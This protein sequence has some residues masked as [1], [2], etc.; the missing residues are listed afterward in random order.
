MVRIFRKRRDMMV[1]GLNSIR[2]ISCVNPK[3]L[4]LFKYKKDWQT[5]L[6][7]QD[8]LRTRRCGFACWLEFCLNGEGYLG[9]L[10][11]LMKISKLHWI[12]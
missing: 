12:E 3:A 2:N 1:S 9:F 6:T 11:K 10:C 7:L 4:C 8:D 5:S